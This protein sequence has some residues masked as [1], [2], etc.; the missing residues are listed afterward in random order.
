MRICKLSLNKSIY[1][2]VFSILFVLLNLSNNLSAKEILLLSGLEPIQ[3][4]GMDTTFNWWAITKPFTNRYRLIINGEESDVYSNVKEPVFS[5]DG[6]KWASFAEYNGF[7]NLISSDTNYQLQANSPGEIVFSG[8]SEMMLYS[9]FVGNLETIIF[10]ERVIEVTNRTGKL[11]IDPTG[12]RFAFLGYRGNS[13]VLNI[14]GTET[15]QYDEIK[16]IGFWYDGNFLYAARNGN[17]W[18]VYSGK[19]QIGDNYYGIYEQKINIH[20]TVA[21]F[22]AKMPNGQYR[23]V[24]ISDEY[25]EPLVGNYYDSIIDLALHPHQT[26]VAY[27][28]M[29]KTNQL[30]LFNNTV[31]S[32]EK[33]CG[34]PVFTIDGDNLYFITCNI[35]CFLVINGKRYEMNSN[36]EVKTT[37]AIKPN[38]RTYAVSSNYTLIKRY[39]EKKNFELDYM[40]DFTITPRY[41]RRNETYE[42]LGVIYDRLY[43]LVQNAE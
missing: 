8:N 29:D 41:N 25:Y 4:F 32:A 14:N 24:T 26:M 21:A 9:Y 13:A 3:N 12:K 27:R 35:D 11:F 40:L 39:L 6:E 17:S 42:T 37:L 34:S 23:V 19:K 2:F 31:Y 7:W 5:P 18:Q 20:G 16:P 43:M 30:I 15:Q 1:G 38:G 10:G 28:A 22:I 33:Y 36:F